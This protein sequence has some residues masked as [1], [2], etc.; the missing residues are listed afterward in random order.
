MTKYS[1]G[2][3]SDEEDVARIVLGFEVDDRRAKPNALSGSDKGGLSVCRCEPALQR[4]KEVAELIFARVKKAREKQNPSPEWAGVVV[5]RAGRLRSL[6]DGPDKR[7]FCIYDTA[8]VNNTGHAEVMQTKHGS[9]KRMDMLRD[10]LRQEFSEL[11]APEDFWD[12]SVLREYKRLLSNDTN[13][14]QGSPTPPP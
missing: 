4:P 13:A 12:G 5:A 7:T 11:I 1:P 10:A 14:H 9:T 8:L 6:P 2:V 3:V